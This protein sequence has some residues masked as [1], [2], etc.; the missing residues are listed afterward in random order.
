MALLDAFRPVAALDALLDAER[1]ALLSGDF[2][3]LAQAA[4][5]KERL[6]A[7]V[8]RSGASVQ[9]LTRLSEKADHN[10]RLL[11]ASARGA[12]DARAR[13]DTLRAPKSFST[14]GPQGTATR[15]GNKSLTMK[16]KA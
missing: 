3:R 2:A 12:R 7:M 9:V 16:H 6:M 10:S 14:Y 15:L 8:A 5:H 13:I 4:E 1:E 11:L